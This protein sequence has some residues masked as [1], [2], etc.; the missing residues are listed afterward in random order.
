MTPDEMKVTN[1]VLDSLGDRPDA[2]ELERVLD[3]VLEMHASL[4]MDRASVNRSRI[5]AEIEYRVKVTVDGSTVMTDGDDGTTHTPWLDDARGS[6]EWTRWA[7]YFDWL[8]ESG[9]DR[10][11]LRELDRST[12]EVLGLLESPKRE[13]SWDRRGLVVGDVQAG[14][15][16]HYIGLINKAADA[17][18]RFIVILA[19]IHEALR[20][21]TQQRVDEGFLGLASDSQTSS[22]GTELIGVGGRSRKH[23]PSWS[24]TSTRHD[25]SG[26]TAQSIKGKAGSEPLVLIVKKNKKILENLVDWST[27]NLGAIEVGESSKFRVHDLPLLVIDDEADHA[28][29]NTKKVGIATDDFGLPIEETTNPSEIN[30]LIRKLLDSFDK[31]A[32]VGYTATPFANI[33]IGSDVEHKDHGHD[34]FPRSFILRI[35]APS[36]YIGAQKIFGIH[37]VDEDDDLSLNVGTNL[38][39]PTIRRVKDHELWLPDKH[40]KGT[41][42]G[43][44]PPSVIEAIRSFVLVCAA[45]CARGNAEQHNSMLIHVTRFNDVQERVLQQVENEVIALREE[46]LWGGTSTGALTGLEELW[47][48]QFEAH[49][50]DFDA[51]ELNTPITWGDV[52]SHLNHALGKIEL[53][54]V[55]GNRSDARL[56]ADGTKFIIA[57]GGDKLSR[58]LTLE[59]L[60]VSYYLRASLAYDTLMQ[61]GRWFGYR[62]GYNDLCRLYTTPQLASMYRDTAAASAHLLH[63]FDRMAAAKA[64]PL[65]FALFVQ[66][67]P[68]LLVTARNK[69]RASSKIKLSYAN[70]SHQTVTFTTNATE[71]ENNNRRISDLLRELTTDATTSA[72][73]APGKLIW[74]HVAPSK[75]QSLVHAWPPAPAAKTV[76]GTLIAEYIGT[77]VAH[78]E[79]LDWTVCVMSN[80]LAE[81]QTIQGFGGFDLGLFTRKANS[82]DSGSYSIGVLSSAPDESLDLTPEQRNAALDATWHHLRS[83]DKD[84]RRPPSP[85]RPE[86]RAQ[87]PKERGLFLL[88]PLV[89]D[90]KKIKAPL[91][92]FC[93]SFPETEAPDL[94]VVEYQ[95]PHRYLEDFY[96]TVIGDEAE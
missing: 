57:I 11:V 34:L 42:P 91:F 41:E 88:Y 45:R 28:S 92:G 1:T 60:S 13:G 52:R 23:P 27:H 2:A 47:S 26:T 7:N 77:R 8:R 82:T 85:G 68:D 36:N 55:N 84:A 74:K 10:D 63:R 3:A 21:Q 81:A 43:D 16:Q 32:Y 29:V 58:G 65:D 33:F 70:E 78:G 49:F 66:T 76:I 53:T 94:G 67:S 59:G 24:F 51:D 54:L 71:L 6:T 86:A 73:H 96:R 95:V 75:V 20:A 61:M 89:P 4:G 80:T 46:I 31:S 56:Y 39:A 50:D 44:L 69:M 22:K 5:K 40:K 72:A 38:V 83:K 64:S 93:I 30:R 37:D 48:S 18:Y 25:F 19:G 14:K 79:L 15:T 35:P 9:R 62:P 90:S 12:D 17:G 87:R